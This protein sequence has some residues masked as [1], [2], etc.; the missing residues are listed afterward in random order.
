[1]ETI[2]KR[3]GIL[4]SMEEEWLMTLSNYGEAQTF[5]PYEI[6]IQQG[7]MND[8]LFIILDG[9]L[10]VFLK[11]D[12]SEIKLAEIT[13]GECFG[14]ISIFEPA[15]ASATV[16]GVTLGHV[17]SMNVDLLQQFMDHHPLEGCTLLLGVNQQLSR[18]LRTVN[19]TIRKHRLPPS[20]VSIRNRIKTGT[21]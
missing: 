12:E 5:Q 18:R 6:L 4:A 11:P 21:P 10:E 9:M 3:E 13:R 15:P 1:M 20:F 19:E 17:W 2:L 8:R 14:E 7:E 16:R